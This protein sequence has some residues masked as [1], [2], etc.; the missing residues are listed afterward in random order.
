M[1]G[2][3][4]GGMTA[5]AQ[6]AAEWGEFAASDTG[7]LQSAW[8]QDGDGSLRSGIKRKIGDILYQGMGIIRSEEGLNRSLAALKALGKSETLT[9]AETD[10]SLLGMAM[11]R[12]ALE[13][14]ESRGAHW[15]EDYP[16]SQE[17][18]RKT[19]V[20]SYDGQQ[21]KVRFRQLPEPMEG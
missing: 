11:L 9:Q 15:R 4:F 19:T 7:S 13:R 21:I 10:E 14:R 17:A 6:A 12:A 2:A 1:L 18:F 8:E 3:V 5:A 16:E 20:V